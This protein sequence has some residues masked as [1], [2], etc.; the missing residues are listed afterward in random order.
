MSSL[1]QDLRYALRTFAKSPVFAVVAI[2]SLMLGI[3]V[4]TAIFTLMDQVLLRMLP[5]K[6]PERL[7]LLDQPG[8]NM[9][10]IRSDHAFS[11]PMYRDFRDRNQVFDG[12]L[13]RASASLSMTHKGQTERIDGEIVSGNY[14]EVL[15]VRP[16]SGR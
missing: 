13:A 6:E 16:A 4:N 5:I 1:L 3:G 8:A 2:A 12:M 15:G 14:F 7:V 9:G 11:Y 10:S